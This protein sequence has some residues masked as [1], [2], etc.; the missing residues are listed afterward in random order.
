M[1]FD[2]GFRRSVK[3]MKCRA[4]QVCPLH[5]LLCRVVGLCRCHLAQF[6]RVS[7]FS[8]ILCRGCWK[9]M[10]SSFHF[11]SCL[12]NWWIEDQWDWGH[13]LNHWSCWIVFLCSFSLYHY[14]NNRC[15]WESYDFSMMLE[16]QQ[17]F[18]LWGSNYQ[19]INF[20]LIW[21]RHLSGRH[22]LGNVP[23]LLLGLGLLSVDKVQARCLRSGQ[24]VA[25]RPLAMLCSC[26]GRW[27]PTRSH[28]F[29]FARARY[30]HLLGLAASIA[31][32][33]LLWF[34]I[35]CHWEWRGH[36]PSSRAW[37]HQNKPFQFWPTNKRCT[38]PNPFGRCLKQP[39]YCLNWAE[40][41]PS[42]LQAS[43]D[44]RDD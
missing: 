31:S 14:L 1:R 8:A 42:S 26:C 15:S 44:N 6:R 39:I 37:L 16:S 29:D 5:Q 33:E 7:E 21:S 32:L 34:L 9:W 30:R 40:S 24:T 28:R 11:W 23:E 41:I 4:N 25:K 27:W 36:L 38:M 17:N 35:H 22:C 43:F 2:L 19:L 18:R 20:W 10:V 12:A 13:I 3:S